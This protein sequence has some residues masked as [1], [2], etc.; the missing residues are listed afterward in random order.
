MFFTRTSLDVLVGNRAIREN[1]A[2]KN[3][4][5]THVEGTSTENVVGGPL[6][7]ELLSGVRALVSVKSTHR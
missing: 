2:V 1:H 5:E 7:D 6:L 3:Y 4:V